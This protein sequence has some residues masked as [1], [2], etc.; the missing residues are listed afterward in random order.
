M[1]ED[2]EGQGDDSEETGLETETQAN[3]AADYL[4][5]EEAEEALEG[6][7]AAEETTAAPVGSDEEEIAPPVINVPLLPVEAAELF[8]AEEAEQYNELS[9]TNPAQAASW[10][11]A[12]MMAQQQRVFQRMMQA[13]TV[14]ASALTRAEM[15][16]PEVFATH[17]NTIRQVLATANPEI[18]GNSVTTF[19]ALV[20]PYILEVQ[21]GADPIATA[22]RMGRMLTRQANAGKATAPPAPM[23]SAKVAPSSSRSSG[24]NAGMNRGRTPNV[25]RDMMELFGAE[26]GDVR[27]AIDVAKGR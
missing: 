7:D 20:A 25:V 12:R 8:T 24:G 14:H 27:R 18:A 5:G 6:T 17:G 3:D 2:Y 1:N 10:L 19:S 26:E 22:K 11:S 4:Y 16:F 21:A 15:E 23:P 9:M 13:Q